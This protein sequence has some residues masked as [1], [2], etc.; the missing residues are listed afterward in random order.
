[1]MKA[2]LN[3]DH[4]AG[5]SCQEVGAAVFIALLT[6]SCGVD[7]SSA[8][9]CSAGPGTSPSLATA[10]AA[11]RSLPRPMSA[12]TVGRLQKNQKVVS[13]MVSSVSVPRYSGDVGRQMLKSSSH[14][15]GSAAAL[16]AGAPRLPAVDQHSP[17]S[18]CRRKV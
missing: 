4:A 16:S 1:M 18:F 7:C 10:V 12:P 6:G 9:G 11:A 17:W 5:S 15:A 13:F 14:A 2:P 3:H 8:G